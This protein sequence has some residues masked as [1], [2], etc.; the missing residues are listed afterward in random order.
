LEGLKKLFEQIDSDKSGFIEPV[1][2]KSAMKIFG[3]S[4][5]EEEVT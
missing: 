5:T 2:F 4:L 3:V 1:E